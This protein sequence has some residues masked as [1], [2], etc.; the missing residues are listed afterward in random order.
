MHRACY[1]T[2]RN[3]TLHGVQVSYRWHEKLSICFFYQYLAPKGAGKTLVY[4][5]A[6]SGNIGTSSCF[7]AFALAIG[8]FII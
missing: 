6:R 8:G 2:L 7:N 1:T 3:A 4:T 5:L